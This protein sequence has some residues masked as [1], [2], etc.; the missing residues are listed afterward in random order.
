MDGL[1]NAALLAL[2]PHSAG[3]GTRVSQAQTHVSPVGRKFILGLAASLESHRAH[4]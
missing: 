4:L 1:G 2:L 3:G